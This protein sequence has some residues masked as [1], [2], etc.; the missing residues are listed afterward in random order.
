M[1]GEELDTTNINN[2]T[3]KQRVEIKGP[4]TKPRGSKDPKTKGS[5]LFT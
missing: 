1:G 4:K 2:S 3:V 5:S